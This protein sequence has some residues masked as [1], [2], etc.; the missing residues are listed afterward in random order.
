MEKQTE[1]FQRQEAKAFEYL[2]KVYANLGVSHNYTGRLIEGRHE[3]DEE[4]IISWLNHN[5][6]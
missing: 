4:A 5:V 6:L 2:E 1:A 3:I